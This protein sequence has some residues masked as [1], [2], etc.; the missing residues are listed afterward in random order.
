MKKLLHEWVTKTF[1]GVDI[2]VCANCARTKDQVGNSVRCRAGEPRQ[3]AVRQHE[4]K[5]R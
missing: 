2:E 1:D 4:G 3:T 5:R